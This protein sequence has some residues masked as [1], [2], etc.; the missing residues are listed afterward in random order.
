MEHV[1]IIQDLIFGNWRIIWGWNLVKSH[2]SRAHRWVCGLVI[3][4]GV[5]LTKKTSLAS[6]GTE[7][8]WDSP[9]ALH[10]NGKVITST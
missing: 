6:G 4:H 2:K 9:H 5:T 8:R 10:P 3:N 7:V 1:R